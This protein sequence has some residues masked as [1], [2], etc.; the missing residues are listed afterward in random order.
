MVTEGGLKLSFFI[1]IVYKTFIY[2]TNN[3]IFI[4]EEYSTEFF[5][6]FNLHSSNEIIFFICKPIVD[7]LFMSFLL[8]LKYVGTK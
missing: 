3:L 1:T 6:S 5:F 7:M 4:S 2:R 8:Y